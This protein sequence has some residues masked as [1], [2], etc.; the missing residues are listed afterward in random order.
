MQ[1][2]FF[3]AA[4]ENQPLLHF[5]AFN[6]KK[7]FHVKSIVPGKVTAV[8]TDPSGCFIF[9]AIE[10]KI[11]VWSVTTRELLNVF[12]AH[13][14]KIS[15]LKIS[16]DGIFLVSGSED[17]SI[18]VYHI[19]S[20]VGLKL[21]GGENVEVHHTYN[22]HMST[23]ADI[24]ITSGQ[25]PRILSVSGQTA[26]LFSLPSQKQLLKVTVDYPITSCT[27]DAGEFR[28]Y[29]GLSNGVIAFINLN[30]E[31]FK[32][33]EIFDASRKTNVYQKLS[34]KHK[35]AV[36][37]LAVSY[38]GTMLV[39]GDLS[40]K[41]FIWSL[42]GNMV[43]HEG[44]FNG[45]II[46][47]AFVRP[48]SSISDEDYVTPPLSNS[49]FHKQLISNQI[50]LATIKEPNADALLERKIEKLLNAYITKAINEYRAVPSSSGDS[51]MEE[52]VELT[53]PSTL[54][55]DEKDKRIQELEKELEEV[56]EAN[57]ELYKM[58][59]DMIVEDDA[60]A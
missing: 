53:P 15:A 16:E 2:D 47:A 23:V 24:F 9:A 41:Y 13:I 21:P 40:G 28:I 11:Y 20:V 38:D 49:S 59:R 33:D 35:D 31:P 12:N 57:A 60:D 14:L 46:K 25:Q 27:M 17:G 8:C 56:Q 39:S 44:S 42:Q 22:P 55:N 37:K 50:E 10:E 18:S 30:I 29:L 45:P 7:R 34:D 54:N 48:W 58:C 36:S 32:I 3:L 6:S 51:V 4:I 1:G 5:I 52:D 26:V 19:K 43:L